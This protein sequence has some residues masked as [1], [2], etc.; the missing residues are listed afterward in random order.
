MNIDKL[1][2]EIATVYKTQIAFANAIRWHVN[3]VSK[4]MT[5]KY[6]PTVDEAAHI[7]DK[8]NLNLEKYSE[9]F[10]T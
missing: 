7:A 5:G 6:I 2:G 8:L 10:L 4:M 9:I 3:K 1:R